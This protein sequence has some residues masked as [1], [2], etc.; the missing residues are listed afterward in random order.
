MTNTN[1]S[2][3]DAGAPMIG[4]FDRFSS[5]SATPS[6]Q[7]GIIDNLCIQELLPPTAV[8]DFTLYR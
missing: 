2:G 1:T 5:I 3:F 6:D 8:R 7:F 4:Y